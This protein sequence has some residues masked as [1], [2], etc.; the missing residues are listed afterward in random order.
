[1]LKN[2]FPNILQKQNFSS[3]NGIWSQLSLG[4][5]NTLAVVIV[6]NSCLNPNLFKDLLQRMR[7]TNKAT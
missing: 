3:L 2:I 5:Q 6:T 4:F 7:R 1:M